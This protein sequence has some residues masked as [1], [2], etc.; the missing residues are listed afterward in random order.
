MGQWSQAGG[1]AQYGA[2]GLFWKNIPQEQ[3]PTDEEYLES[4][5]KVWVEPFGDMRQELVFIGQDID[6]TA[7]INALD[8]CLLND[9]ELSKGEEFWNTLSDPFLTWEQV[10]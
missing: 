4:I 5:H 3:W 9:D 8:Q 2:A 6:K 10:E 1:T 7:M